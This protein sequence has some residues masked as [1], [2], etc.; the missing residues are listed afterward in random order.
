MFASVLCHSRTA[1]IGVPEIT[2]NKF[3]AFDGD[4]DGEYEVSQ[5]GIKT[6]LL[7]TL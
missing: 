4:D 1:N 3:D 5:A 7:L 2:Q 6:W